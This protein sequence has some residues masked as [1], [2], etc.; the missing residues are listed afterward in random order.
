MSEINVTKELSEFSFPINFKTIYQ[1]QRKDP[2]LMANL[3]SI[4]YKRGSFRGGFDS[5]Y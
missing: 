4:K 2:N 3:K 1:Y 5:P